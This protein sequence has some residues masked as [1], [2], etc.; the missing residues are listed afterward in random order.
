MLFG[1]SESPGS[2]RMEDDLVA[3][4]VAPAHDLERLAA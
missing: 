2:S 4:E 3:G 1:C